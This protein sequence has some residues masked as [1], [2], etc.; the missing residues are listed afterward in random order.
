LFEPDLANSK[1]IAS[2]FVIEK[3]LEEKTKR[4]FFTKILREPSAKKKERTK[5]ACR[6]CIE[7]TPKGRRWLNCGQ[8]YLPK[9]PGGDQEE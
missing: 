5:V 7:T 3:G 9:M 6:I 8:S 2:V 4:P 1:G